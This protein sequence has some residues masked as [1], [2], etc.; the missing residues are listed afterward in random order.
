MSCRDSVQIPDDGDFAA[1]REECECE[2]GWN[3]SYSKGGVR[4][5]VRA[6][7]APSGV[8]SIKCRMECR[9]VA[10]ATLYDVLHDSDYRRRWD[11]NVIHS[12]DIG[13]LTA[14]ADVGYYACEGRYGAL[15]GGMGVLWGRM[16]VLWGGMGLYGAGWV[17]YGAEWVSYACEGRY[18]ALWG[19]M[20]VLWGG[21][22]VLCV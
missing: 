18:G 3:V 19:G 1:F 10:A 2:R 6:G 9:D 22:G 16:G 13:R 14:N 21:M 20:G 5:W 15:W 11:S 8:H 12:F 17:S 7:G 4:V